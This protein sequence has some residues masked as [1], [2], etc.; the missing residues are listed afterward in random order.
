LA[1][2]FV[3]L[4]TFGPILSLG[5]VLAGEVVMVVMLI[6]LTRTWRRQIA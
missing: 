6:P 3:L 4:F 5:G 1:V 2:T